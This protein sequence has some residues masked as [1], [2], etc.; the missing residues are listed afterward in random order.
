MLSTTKIPFSHSFN[1]DFI[2][3]S[4]QV[5]YHSRDF[6]SSFPFSALSFSCCPAETL[7][8]NNVHFPGGESPI[9]SC[10]ISRR[11]REELLSRSRNTDS[12][13][14]SHPLSTWMFCHKRGKA[15]SLYFASHSLNPS[16]SS[17]RFWR[18]SKAKD[19]ASILL[20][21][22]SNTCTSCVTS[23]LVPSALRSFSSV[24][25][26]AFCLLSSSIVAPS[27]PPCNLDNSELSCCGSAFCSSRSFSLRESSCCKD[28]SACVR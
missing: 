8:S 10:T 16:L 15:S 7:V 23:R 22:C 2:P 19:L 27:I 21:C 11:S 12:K 26:S 17:S 28:F 3:T 20:T 18:R 6:Q 5:R 4:S 14:F 9:Q 13:A 25:A 24:L 1:T